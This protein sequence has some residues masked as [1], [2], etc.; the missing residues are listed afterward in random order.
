MKEIKSF[1]SLDDVFKDAAK[2]IVPLLVNRD[3]FEAEFQYELPCPGCGD[4]TAS[5]L[6][7]RIVGQND[8]F[9]AGQTM[10]CSICRDTEAFVFYQN[11]SLEELKTSI[12]SR[13]VREYLFIPERLQEAGFKNYVETNG[14]TAGAKHSAISF[15][16][17]FINSENEGHNLLIMGNPGTGKTHLCAAIARTVKEKG[18]SVGFLTTGKALSMIKATYQKGAAKTEAD[19]LQDLKKLD[20]LILDD[21]GSEAMGGN[22]DWRKG[23]IFEIVESRSGKP[24]IYTSNLTDTDL[25]DAVGKRVFS[26]LYDNT[27]F[28][29]LF[30]DDYR[31]NLKIG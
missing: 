7:Y 8:W 9:P 26:R 4:K 18:F 27:K 3:D 28:I 24:T 15:T 20:L 14:V 29:D 1:L 17:E 16:R 22:D 12:V 30:T 10:K 19:I 5:G 6:F 25:P 23:M 31:K 2:K 13:L 11:T 21:V